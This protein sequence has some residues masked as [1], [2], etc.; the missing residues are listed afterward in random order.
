[1]LRSLHGELNYLKMWPLKS[2]V[3]IILKQHRVSVCQPSK[4][5]AL[6]E[7]VSNSINFGTLSLRGA[8]RLRGVV[9]FA[10]FFC[11]LDRFEQ[12][13]LRQAMICN[14]NED[15]CT[16]IRRTRLPNW[17]CKLLHL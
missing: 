16:A 3:N 11:L 10:S 12:V 2:K 14:F 8:R 9:P 15:P 6:V 13:H 17:K 5:D 7:S 1:M 4:I